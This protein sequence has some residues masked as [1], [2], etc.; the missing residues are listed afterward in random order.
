MA[1]NVRVRW[2]LPTIR[3]DGTLLT[4]EE[5]MGTEVSMRLQG[6]TTWTLLENVLA[7]N[8]V[9]ELFQVDVDVG[10]WEL[11]LVVEDK[12]MLRSDNFIIPFT[13]PVDS[14]PG[15]SPPGTVVNVT[16]TLE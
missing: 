15:E 14:V 7:V 5:I 9:N 4:F 3:K 13:V 1:K 2:G 10:T 11:L 16:V 8:G 12:D 6:A